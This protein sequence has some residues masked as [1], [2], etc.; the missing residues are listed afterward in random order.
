MLDS[1]SI[2]DT[3]ANQ[4]LQVA[5]GWQLAQQFAVAAGKQTVCVSTGSANEREL[6]RK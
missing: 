2:P 5:S 6:L 3:F 1:A 4:R